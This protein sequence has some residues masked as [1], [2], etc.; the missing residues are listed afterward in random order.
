MLY[1]YEQPARQPHPDFDAGLAGRII[2]HAEYHTIKEY[3]DAIHRDHSALIEPHP[4]DEI[5]FRQIISTVRD[6]T[7]PCPDSGLTAPHHAPR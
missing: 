5:P 7:A 6:Q 4:H 3:L 1:V 2:M